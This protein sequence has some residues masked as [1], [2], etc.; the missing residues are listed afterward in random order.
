M[1]LVLFAVMALTRSKNAIR[2]RDN[3]YQSDSYRELYKQNGWPSAF[4][5]S[6]FDLAR[7][8]WDNEFENFF[9]RI[10]TLPRLAAEKDMLGSID[11]RIKDLENGL[12]LPGDH[13]H[14]PD[15][16]TTGARLKQYMTD[17]LEHAKHKKAVVMQKIEEDE[18]QAAEIRAEDIQ[19]RE[20]IVEKYG[21]IRPLQYPQ[22][23]FDWRHEAAIQ[24][25]RINF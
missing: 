24:E 6:G 13:D 22:K 1:I 19:L 10:R 23:Q 11:R 7:K 9:F 25:A 17:K 15:D 8:T 18:K 2:S 4:D 16:I 5:G 12:L 20:S 21:F 3:L 14:M